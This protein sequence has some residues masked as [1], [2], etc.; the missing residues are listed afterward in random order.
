MNN[1]TTYKIIEN[2]KQL[3]KNFNLTQADLAKKLNLSFQQISNLENGRRN[4]TLEQALLLNQIFGVS[5]D[6]ILGI[7]SIPQNINTEAVS[8]ALIVRI[9]DI[10]EQTHKWKQSAPDKPEAKQEILDLCEA[11]RKIN[12]N[13]TSKLE[14][15]LEIQKTVELW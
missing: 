1:I 4:L 10:Y 15:I 13:R 8:K 9:N 7:S 12:K 3:R 5:V 14:K 2:L 6:W 11:Y